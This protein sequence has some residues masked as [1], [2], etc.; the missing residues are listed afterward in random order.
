MARICYGYMGISGT[1]SGTKEILQ[2][3]G[4]LYSEDLLCQLSICETSLSPGE[5]YTILT[6]KVA[7]VVFGLIYQ[8]NSELSGKKIGTNLL[9]SDLSHVVIPLGFEPRTHTLKVY[10]ST[11]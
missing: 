1:D 6:N 4:F 2:K 5:L 10:C 7:K 11:S 8:K 3:N 9:F